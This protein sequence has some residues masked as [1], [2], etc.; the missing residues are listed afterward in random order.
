MKR[1]RWHETLK[2]ARAHRTLADPSDFKGFHVYKWKFTKK[3]KPFF[4]GT[5]LEL[6]N[7]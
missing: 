6:L 2:E 4:V 1:I 3:K 7:V 5:E